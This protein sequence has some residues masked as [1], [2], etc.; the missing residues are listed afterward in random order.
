[1]DEPDNPSHEI[2]LLLK[3]GHHDFGHAYGNL[4]FGAHHN[5]PDWD[6]IRVFGAV[7]VAHRKTVWWSD[8]AFPGHHGVDQRNR[9]WISIRPLAAFAPDWDHLADS[10]GDCDPGALC[11]SHGGRV[12]CEVCHRGHLGLVPKPVCLRGAVV[13]E[14]TGAESFGSHTER[15]AV[16]GCSVGRPAY[17]LESHGFGR[18]E[19]P[20][21]TGAR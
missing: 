15:A 7:R 14:S 9:V 2:Q 16:P 8:R 4:H 13:P 21:R 11:V 10:P 1:M 18:Q 3:G 5:Q 20:S 19:I 17:F 12:A 6:R